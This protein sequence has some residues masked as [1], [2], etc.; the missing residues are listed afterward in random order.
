MDM[1]QAALIL[2]TLL[3]LPL[4][5]KRTPKPP[6]LVCV[7]VMDQG[8]YHYIPTL[9]KF[10]RHGI[11]TFLD[12]GIVY[13]NA[14]Y[15]HAIPKTVTGHHCL[16][17]GALPNG[18]GAPL[19]SWYAPDGSTEHYDEDDMAS[20][21][22]NDESIN[23]GK[24]SRKTVTDG[25]SDQFMLSQNRH[26]KCF[27]FSLSLKAASALATATRMGKPIW[28]DEK[29]GG[30]TSSSA[31]FKQ[32]PDWVKRFNREKNFECMTSFSW[33]LLYP[34][35]DPGYQLN[36]IK[37]YDYAEY[38]YS[39]I[40]KKTMVIKKEGKKRFKQFL[41]TPG[42]SKI[43]IDFAK[44]CLIKHT[45]EKESTVFMWILFSNLDFLCR[46]YGPKSLET[47]DLLYHL[48]AQIGD[49]MHMATSRL[50][51]KNCLFVLT[52]DHGIAPIPELA[53]K[54]G[55]TMAK[56][57]MVKPVIEAV[58]EAVEKKYGIKHAITGFKPTYFT[59]DQKEPHVLDA[60]KELLEKQT[61]I[62]KVWTLQDLERSSYFPGQREYA[63]KSQVYPGR[64]GDLMCMP[65][66]YCQLTGHSKGTSHQTP[67]EYDTHVP[68]VLYQA[69]RLEKKV[70]TNKVFITQLAPTL[71]EIM[72]ISRPATAMEPILPG[73]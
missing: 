50:G 65:Q 9:K 39:M 30:F 14:Y 5:A 18:H 53:A 24:S 27:A 37:N 36:D 64:V 44:Q 15:P 32:L 66:P 47:I 70:I 61:G 31:Y 40:A 2:S 52:A 23:E 58:N 19:N 6:K 62:R 46:F 42:A 72:G 28:F 71:A 12:N 4:H 51:E 21:F 20:V 38:P 13:E 56:R 48:D 35:N 10:F 43:L 49:F 7:F 3:F 29:R 33:Q 22:D 1:R 8:A 25:I 17:T 54:N 41:Q 45:Q 26:K 11:K 68:L 63:Y 55:L 59:S 34:E 73:V 69:G 16:S 57:V 60:I 67:Y